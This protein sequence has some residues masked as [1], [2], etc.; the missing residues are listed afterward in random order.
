MIRR[1]GIAAEVHLP[2][3]ENVF[4]FYLYLYVL[5]IC[6][7]INKHPL[8][9]PSYSSKVSAH[10]LCISFALHRESNEISFVF[11]LYLYKTFDRI[12]LV[13]PL[14][15]YRLIYKSIFILLVKSKNLIFWSETK[16]FLCKEKSVLKRIF[17]TFK[18]VCIIIFIKVLQGITHTNIIVGV[19]SRAHINGWRFWKLKIWIKSC[20]R[21]FRI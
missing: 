19:V 2:V 11:P 9:T 15:L 5:C 12:R 16:T 4:L 17:S 20:S 1:V 7:G 6:M 13:V 8:H 14:Y 3:I 10:F 21:I 18:T